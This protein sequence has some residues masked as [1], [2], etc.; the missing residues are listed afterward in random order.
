VGLY[1]NL[2]RMVLHQGKLDEAT[3]LY[4]EQ[5][6]LMLRY[7][8]L[9]VDT[10]QMRI[11]NT[12]T[13]L[14][15]KGWNTQADALL[16]ASEKLLLQRL[17]QGA[18]TA[19]GTNWLAD[20]YSDQGRHA[21]AEVVHRRE[22]ERIQREA[23]D[24]L[25]KVAV[26]T[27]RLAQTLGRAHRHAE[28]EALRRELLARQREKL[29][30]DHPDIVT[31]LRSLAGCVQAQGRW[32]ESEPMLREA[33]AMWT[34]IGVPGEVESPFS[35]SIFSLSEALLRQGR[36]AEAE[37]V[38][39]ERLKDLRARRPDDQWGVSEMEVA[40]TRVLLKE[41]KF[42]QAEPLAREALGFQEK[43]L[44]DAWATF[45]TRSLLGESL[46]GQNRWADAGPLLL[47]GYE[48][49]KR[50]E[51]KIMARDRVRLREALQRLAKFEAMA[52]QPD[53][54]AAWQRE[55]EEFDRRSREG[56]RKE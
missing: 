56:A 2:T 8:A 43:K 9:K 10:L 33:L 24:N 11:R 53:R 7:P 26:A 28:G 42:P 46:L 1:D 19:Q 3:A 5:I 40:L 54:A 52:G 6:D 36:L 27:L 51:D 18:E 16:S 32:A 4:Q 37:Q 55:L 41:E 34:R 22:W 17:A 13:L 48:G 31:S 21:E 50:L 15:E 20:V 47:S 38:L 14:K 29:G 25:P 23:P 49:M 30:P 39:D 35:N 45:E 44:P 12:A